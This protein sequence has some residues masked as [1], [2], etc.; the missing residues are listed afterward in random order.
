VMDGHQ[1]TARI[2]AD[3]RFAAL[4]I[5]AMTAHATVE[6]RDAC[7]ANGMNGHIPK[8][9]EPA[10]LFGTLAT[11][12]RGSGTSAAPIAPA[13]PKEKSEALPQVA[14]LDTGDGLARVAG[15]AKLYLKLLRQFAEQQG[16]AIEN[17]TAALAANDQATAERLAHTLKGVAGNLGATLVQAAAGALEKVIRLKSPAT[18]IEAKLKHTAEQLA[19]ILAGLKAT[20]AEPAAASAAPGAPADPA[21]SRAAALHVAKLLADFDASAADYVEANLPLLQPVLGAAN[22]DAFLGHIKGYAFPDALALLQSV[23]PET[24]T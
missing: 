7:L 20:L 13:A 18:E 8:P 16:N 4:P 9:I 3:S 5:I 15:N 17:I 10:V 6:E 21:A 12:H 22:W 23:V 14:G 24:R 1:A 19:P 11:L 2:R